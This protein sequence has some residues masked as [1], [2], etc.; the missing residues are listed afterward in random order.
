[1]RRA[2]FSQARIGGGLYLRGAGNE[3]VNRHRIR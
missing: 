1:M 3:A 2:V